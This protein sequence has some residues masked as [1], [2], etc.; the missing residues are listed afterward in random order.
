MRRNGILG[1]CACKYTTKC[2]YSNVSQKI[3]KNDN[4]I[5]VNVYL[6]IY[7][8]SLTSHYVQYQSP[9][10]YKLSRSSQQYCKMH[11]STPYDTFGRFQGFSR[12]WCENG[13]YSRVLGYP[14]KELW[15]SRVFQRFLWICANP[16]NT[17]LGRADSHLMTKAALSNQN[18]NLFKA[19]TLSYSWT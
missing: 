19:Y 7:N 16:V 6:H 11:K 9:K 8:A 18:T 13:Q 1:H 5:A 12:V 4:I 14:W 3:K 17:P 15:N 2:N 10:V